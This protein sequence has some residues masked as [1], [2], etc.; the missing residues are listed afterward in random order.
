MPRTRE[1]K[2]ENGI[3][4]WPCRKCGKWLPRES[5]YTDK[6]L[7]HGKWGGIR[8]FCKECMLN[9]HKNVFLQRPEIQEKERQ[10]ARTRGQTLEHK[11]RVMTRDAVKSGKLERPKFCPIC[12]ISDKK[13]Q[14]ESHHDDYYRPLEVKWM[15]TTCHVAYHRRMETGQF[16]KPDQGGF[17]E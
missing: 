17:A 5:Y 7:L 2:I 14:I 15:C 13:R 11:C 1:T 9:Y 12:G 3:Q 10:R 8:G 16:K 6:R 4:L